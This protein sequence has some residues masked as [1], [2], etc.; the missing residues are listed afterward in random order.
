M[1]AGDLRVFEAVARLGGMHR[2]AL[3]LN[4]V[5]SN[6]TARIKVLEQEL[7]VAL[8]RR[9]SRGVAI[10]NAGAR[11]LPYATKIGALLAEAKRLVG[12]DDE[13]YGPLTIGSLETTAAQRLS[14]VI[15]AF[16]QANPA[17][18]LSLRVGTNEAMLA[19]VLAHELDGAFV[20]GPVRHTELSATLVFREELVLASADSASGGDALLG[21]ACTILVKGPGCAYRERFEAYIQGRGVRKVRR[22][23]FGTL[24]AILG[25]VESGL[26][27]T[28]LPR[29]VL[30]EAERAGRVRLH[31]LPSREA[32]VDTVFVRRKDVVEFSAMRAFLACALTHAQTQG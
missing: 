30:A 3:E 21:N 27:V 14:P 24:E 25:C 17:V 5:Q 12:G 10:T 26:G 1:D 8:F 16:S 29:S 20:C 6:V 7:G 22:L 15:T 4:T 32:L 2:A 28:M 23:Q 31:P 11:L 9:H 18:Q 13:P 19:Q